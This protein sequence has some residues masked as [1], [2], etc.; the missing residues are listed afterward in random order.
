MIHKKIFAAL[1]IL[2]LAL[3]S[4][5]A[6]KADTV[7]GYESTGSVLTDIESRAKAM[8]DAGQLKPADCQKLKS[9]Y[10]RAR[11]AYI[12]SGDALVLAIDT[13]DA[14]TKQKSLAAYQ[15]AVSD[16]GALLPELIT[17]AD[18][19]GIKPTPYPSQEGNSKVSSREGTNGGA[20]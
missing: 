4:C 15:Q 11:A 14:A 19:L 6:W 1:V 3:S 20:K 5:A 16:L 18:Q 7:A 10:N 8:C 12:T 2:F 9:A 13:Q 17:A